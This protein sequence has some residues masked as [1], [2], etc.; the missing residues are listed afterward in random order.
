[1]Q[2]FPN[3]LILRHQRENL[4]KCSLRG[5]ES[6]ADMDFLTYPLESLPPLDN[7]LMLT[8]DAP[9]ISTDDFSKGFLFIDGTWLLAAKMEKFVDSRVKLEKRSLP[10]HYRTAYPRKQTGCPDAERGLATVEAL[11]LTYLLSGR[12]TEGLLDHYYWKEL[13][14]KSLVYS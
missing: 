10:S 11:Y 4:N 5:L 13:F 8:V 3:T 6:R 14:L 2:I 12:S 9:P 7:Y 1:M